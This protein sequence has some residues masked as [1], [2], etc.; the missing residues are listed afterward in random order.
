MAN[1]AHEVA[2]E[3]R[4]AKYPLVEILAE[5]V[6]SALEWE[7]N[8]NV[9]SKHEFSLNQDSTVID[10]PPTDSQSVNPQGEC[11]DDGPF[12]PTYQDL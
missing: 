7:A 9:A 11:D 2:E 1:R 3:S 5:M 4:L 10:C 6:E 12:R 8:N